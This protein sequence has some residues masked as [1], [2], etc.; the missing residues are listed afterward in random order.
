MIENKLDKL[1]EKIKLILTKALTNNLI[2][3][4]S[5]IN[6]EKYFFLSGSQ[7]YLVFQPIFSYFT[8][9]Q[10]DKI[11]SLKSKGMSEESIALP[12]TTNNSFVIW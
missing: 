6:G 11:G 9:G 7:C 4:Y 10:N 3:K 8:V 5:I 2:D 1:S 12:S